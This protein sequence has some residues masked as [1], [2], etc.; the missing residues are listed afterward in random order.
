MAQLMFSI[1]CTSKSRVLIDNL[2]G[3][4]LSRMSFEKQREKVMKTP[5]EIFGAVAMIRN[6]AILQRISM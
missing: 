2:Y 4:T 6:G 3:H 5:S 1:E